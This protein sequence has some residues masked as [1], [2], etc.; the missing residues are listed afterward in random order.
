MFPKPE[1]YHGQIKCIKYPHAHHPAASPGK[2][3]P[4]ATLQFWWEKLRIHRRSL[5]LPKARLHSMKVQAINIIN[6]LPYLLSYQLPRSTNQLAFQEGRKRGPG[7]TLAQG[8]M[9]SS[10]D[11]T[12]PQTPAPSV[13]RNINKTH[14][15]TPSFCLQ[16]LHQVYLFT[17][18][19]FT[20]LQIKWDGS[21]H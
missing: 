21:K 3:N 17:V 5:Q 12:A 7:V 14:T 9:L 1:C 11:S 20:V 10:C 15:H 13:W 6:Y 4:K 8:I 18:S 16:M 19:L 2:E